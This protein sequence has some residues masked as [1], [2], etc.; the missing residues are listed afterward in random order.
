MRRFTPVFLLRL[1][2]CFLLSQIELSEF[3]EIIRKAAR[4]MDGL[5]WEVWSGFGD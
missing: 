2:A 1:H 4:K 3:V 5:E